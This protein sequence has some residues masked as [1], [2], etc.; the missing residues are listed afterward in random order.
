MQMHNCVNGV[1]IKIMLKLFGIS[2][3]IIILRQY[4]KHWLA[5]YDTISQLKVN[6]HTTY[7]SRVYIL[8]LAIDLQ[9]LEKKNNESPAK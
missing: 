8:S 1:C 5:L 3:T 9:L 2:K 7:H 6:H 4:S